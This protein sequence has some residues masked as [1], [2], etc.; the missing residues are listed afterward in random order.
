M[1]KTILLAWIAIAMLSFGA[2]AQQQEPWNSNQLVRPSDLAAKIQKG[3][4]DN[5]LIVNIGPDAVI[6]GSVDIGP[7][8]DAEN[9]AKL[10]AHLKSVPKYKEVILYCGCCPFSKCPNIRP[11]FKTLAEM[12]FVNRKLLDIPKNIKVDWLDKGYPVNE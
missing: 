12:G 9:I 1:P 11:T 2:K 7:G 10:K 4:A 8:Q 5:L 6:K 3:Q